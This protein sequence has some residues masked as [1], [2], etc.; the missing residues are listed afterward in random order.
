MYIL[1]QFDELSPT[2]HKKLEKQIT[3]TLHH[4]YLTSFCGK[5]GHRAILLKNHLITKFLLRAVMRNLEN[6]K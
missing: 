4:W 6:V 5:M 3:L 1:A 2:T